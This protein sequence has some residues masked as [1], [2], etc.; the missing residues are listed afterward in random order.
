MIDLEIGV[1]HDYLQNGL[2][3]VVGRTYLEIRSSSGEPRLTSTPAETYLGKHG[4]RERTRRGG[5]PLRGESPREGGLTPAVYDRDSPSG[6]RG[7]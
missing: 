1:A 5:Y 6:G 4:G 3:I 7:D 2:K